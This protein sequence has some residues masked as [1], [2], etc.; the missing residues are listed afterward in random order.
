MLEAYYW[1][2][3][4]YFPM[5]HESRQGE[6]TQFVE[7]LFNIISHGQAGMR[8]LKHRLQSN[9]LILRSNRQIDVKDVDVPV[10][11]RHV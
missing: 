8:H 2:Y 7:D 11:C 3:V 10:H 5:H 6:Y 9:W 4:E 1:V